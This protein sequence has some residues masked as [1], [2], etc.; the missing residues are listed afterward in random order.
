VADIQNPQHVFNNDGTY[1]VSLLVTDANGC[2]GVQTIEHLIQVFPKPTA[3]FIPS[4]NTVSIINPVIQFNNISELNVTNFWS[5]NDGDSSLQISPTHKFLN[6]GSYIVELTVTSDKGCIDTAVYTV[7]VKVEFTVYAPNA[8]TVDQDGNNEVFFINGTNISAKDFLLN[9]Y[10]RWGEIIFQTN[11][12]NPDNPVQY[13][14][15]GKT[16]SGDYVPVGT[17]TWLVHFV[18]MNGISHEKTG[19]VT[20]IR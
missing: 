6:V 19:S 12:F 5:F 20:V 11:K 1:D 15:N 9:I 2:K 7:V 18:D 17:Y 3:A 16:K 14:W 4:P 8:I 13:G 10:D